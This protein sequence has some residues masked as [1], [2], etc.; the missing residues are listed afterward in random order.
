[1]ATDRQIAAN[2]A[3]AQKST[4]PR[5]AAGKAA[6]SANAIKSGIYAQ[7][8]LIPGED[9]AEYDA[10]R[11]EHYD[12]FAPANPDER[13]LLDL[14]IKYKWQL[15]RLQNCYDQMWLHYTRDD[16]ECGN[17]P[18]AH[19]FIRANLYNPNLINLSRMIHSTDRAFH[20]TRAALIKTQDQRRRAESK[21]TE[22]KPSATTPA[23]LP[24]QP[25]LIEIGFVPSRTPPLPQIA[26]ECSQSLSSAPCVLSP[27]LRASAPKS[28]LSWNIVQPQQPRITP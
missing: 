19:V 28:P 24:A 26:S 14:M 1:M 3:N 16:S 15:R 22:S 5:T 13:D 18:L 27:R 23:T 2:R 25:P 10:L 12:H 20:R 17:S 11:Q 8:I 4:G 6:S 9:P 7:S 21:V